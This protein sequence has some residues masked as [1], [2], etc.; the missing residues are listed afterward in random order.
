MV[1]TSGHSIT[2]SDLRKSSDQPGRKRRSSAA[3]SDCNSAREVRQP[4]HQHV[5]T[6]GPGHDVGGDAYTRFDERGL[7]G[8]ESSAPSPPHASFLR[9]R[10]PPERAR[11]VESC[12]APRRPDP[13]GM[14][15]DRG[16]P[17]HRAGRRGARRDV[18]HGAASH[19]GRPWS[20]MHRRRRTCC[21]PTEARGPGPGG[22]LADGRAA[23][24]PAGG[25]SGRPIAREYLHG[26]PRT[27]VPRAG[28]AAGSRAAAVG[29]GSPAGR[30][31]RPRRRARP[32]HPRRP[33]HPDRAACHSGAAGL[34]DGHHPRDREPEPPGAHRRRGD[35]PEERQ[36]RA[37][38]GDSSPGL[39]GP[40]GDSWRTASRHRSHSVAS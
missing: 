24:R 16:H 4:M 40:R 30:A 5:R 15:A 17:G 27:A 10:A 11:V 34:D 39:A 3:T 28:A 20:R 37:Q 25:G 29:A 13:S 31:H 1:V 21:P 18:G 32:T 26:A 35:H 33:G 22:L 23:G 9:H 2:C 6:H 12:P 36:V 14:G 8:T 7:R 19:P 38:A